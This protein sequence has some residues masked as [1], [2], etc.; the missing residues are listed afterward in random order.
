MSRFL[1]GEIVEAICNVTERGVR[2]G[3][4]YM[5]VNHRCTNGDQVFENVN[6]GMYVSCCPSVMVLFGGTVMSVNLD[7]NFNIK[8]GSLNY[9]E[10]EDF[11][12]ALQ[13][14][15]PVSEGTSDIPWMQADQATQQQ[16]PA[17]T[18]SSRHQLGFDMQG[19]TGASL[20]N[21]WSNFVEQTSGDTDRR[22]QISN[23][24]LSI[25]SLFVNQ[26]PDLH[27]EPIPR[28]DVVRSGGYRGATVATEG[29]QRA[30]Y[31]D[32]DLRF[33]DRRRTSLRQIRGEETGVSS[34]RIEW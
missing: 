26:H 3:M 15:K 29:P 25:D 32:P 5:A 13:E 24:Q 18:P 27:D 17:P 11:Y 23:L 4:H 10:Q 20:R 19:G 14:W 30:R 8:S 2:Q 33:S 28:N 22:M 16:V 1:T 7:G 9:A 12:T 34:T 6:T 31:I 21:E